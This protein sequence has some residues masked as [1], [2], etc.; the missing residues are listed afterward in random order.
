MNVAE[1][2][3]A[4]RPLQF[5]DEALVRGWLNEPHIAQ[6]GKDAEKAVREAMGHV[7]AGDARAFVIQGNGHD[8][9]YIQA[10]DALEHSYFADR[11]PGTAGLD[12]YLGYADLIGRGMGRR[13][14]ADFS[15]RLLVAGA[16]AVVANPD[17]KNRGAIGAYRHAGFSLDQVHRSDAHGHLI[18]MSKTLS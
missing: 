12:L 2:A 7:A 14:I 3:I 5:T 10:Y 8:L 15:G 4:F 13:V 1:V 17:P 9:G 6:W 16:P 18:L 11:A